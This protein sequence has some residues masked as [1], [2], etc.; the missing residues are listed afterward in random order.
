MIS[1]VIWLPAMFINTPPNGFTKDI[2]VIKLNKARFLLNFEGNMLKLG[3][4]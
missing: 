4:F 3:E 2:C 1:H